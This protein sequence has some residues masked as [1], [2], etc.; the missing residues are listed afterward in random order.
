MV[1]NKRSPRLENSVAIQ[2]P[3][4]DDLLNQL[5]DNIDPLTI[6]QTQLNILEQALEK[7]R[8]EGSLSHLNLTSD[9]IMIIKQEMKNLL[10]SRI[11]GVS[12]KDFISVHHKGYSGGSS[13]KSTTMLNFGMK[14][15]TLQYS[16][17]E[18]KSN[19][20][21][22]HRPKISTIVNFWKKTKKKN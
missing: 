6:A 17:I 19:S 8:V 9:D 13:F 11:M 4:E 22:R 5:I 16:K 2:F 12:V 15:P 10:Q 1:M 3:E 20:I 7:I 18:S 14:D 21:N